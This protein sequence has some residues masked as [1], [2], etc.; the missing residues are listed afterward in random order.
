MQIN[1]ILQ[2]SPQKT[3]FDM[4]QERVPHLF[5]KSRFLALSFGTHQKKIYDPFTIFMKK[6]KK[7]I[8]Q[9]KVISL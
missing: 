9:V 1:E 7:S 4:Y 8:T 2:F 6:K 3:M 5:F